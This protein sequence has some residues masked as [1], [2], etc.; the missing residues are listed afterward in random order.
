MSASPVELLKSEDRTQKGCLAAPVRPENG[1]GPA[2]CDIERQAREETQIAE[3]QGCVTDPD[4]GCPTRVKCR[5]S[6]TA[7]TGAPIS[8]VRTPRGL[9]AAVT[10]RARVSTST[11]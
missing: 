7:K 8:A 10:V 3:G 1:H 2:A 11:R 6:S 5:R 4:H 9:S